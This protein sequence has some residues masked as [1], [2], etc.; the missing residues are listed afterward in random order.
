M[1]TKA[2]IV[3]LT[4]V[5]SSLAAP[6]ATS[7]NVERG[8]EST[9]GSMSTMGF[10]IHTR[11]EDVSVLVKDTMEEEP[12]KKRTGYGIISGGNDEA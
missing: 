12:I 11:E 7:S 4:L 5:A 3:A 2:I 9:D 10:G 1:Q 6:V 8:T